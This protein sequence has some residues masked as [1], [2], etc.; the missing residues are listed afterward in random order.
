MRQK[1]NNAFE[2]W[3]RAIKGSLGYVYPTIFKFID[4][5]RREQSVAKNKL[6]NL[7]AGKEFPKNTFTIKNILDGHQNS[8][9]ELALNGLSNNFDFVKYFKLS[10]VLYPN[11]LCVIFVLNITQL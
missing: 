4:F 7:Q 3:H 8:Q 6:I 9:I 10:P 11:I 1:T 5:L 2:G